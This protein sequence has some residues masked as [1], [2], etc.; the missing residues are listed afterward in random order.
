MGDDLVGSAWVVAWL[1]VTVGAVTKD[2]GQ[3][4]VNVGQDI[5][6]GRLGKAAQRFLA[7]P[8]SLARVFDRLLL[9]GSD[10]GQAAQVRFGVGRAVD[11]ETQT[12]T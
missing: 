12:V 1:M 7:F 4:L 11:A 8:K 10:F 5:S 9:G 3:G 2:A 6:Q